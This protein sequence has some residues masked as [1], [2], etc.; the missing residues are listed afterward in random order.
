MV[1]ECVSQHKQT[2]HQL[3]ASVI[4]PHMASPVDSPETSLALAKKIFK[5]LSKERYETCIL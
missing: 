4:F 3:G 5:A 2:C 1:L